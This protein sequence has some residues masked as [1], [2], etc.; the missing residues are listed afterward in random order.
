MLK[1]READHSPSCNVDVKN[2]EKWWGSSSSTNYNWWR[3]T[4]TSPYAFS[5]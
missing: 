3:Y 2:M 5:A 1:G 4:Y